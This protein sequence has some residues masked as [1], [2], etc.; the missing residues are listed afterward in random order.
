MS[1]TMR[2]EVLPSPGELARTPGME[3]EIRR[4]AVEMAAQIVAQKEQFL[5]EPFFRSRQVAYELKRLQNV[6]E[7]R[8]WKI[9]YARF[10]CMVCETT[11]RIHGGC[12]MCSTCYCNNLQRLKQIRGEQIREEIARP[13]RGRLRLDRL[14]PENA[15]AHRI[16]H[17]RYERCTEK[18]LKVITRVA[19]QLGLTKD[20]VRAVAVGL[21]RSHAVS[22]ALK[23]ETE[24]PANRGQQ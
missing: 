19:E 18:E 20:Y 23:K 4:L 3:A 12:G 14:I 8:T 9:Y 11:E 6:P 16:H 5:F 24:R 2:M 10:G 22:A 7:Q 17:T 13:A 1:K 21:R 15:P